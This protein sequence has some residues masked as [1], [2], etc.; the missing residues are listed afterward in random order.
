MEF[1]EREIQKLDL[2]VLLEDF[3]REARRLLLVGLA[4]VVLCGALM[5][6]RTKL[7]YHPQYQ[8]SASFT[9]KVADPL[10][11]SISAY[12]TKTAEQMAKTFPYILTNGL[13]QDRIREELGI[14]YMPSVSVSVM[15]NSSVI[16]LSVRDG[17]PNRA[18]DV[19]NAVITHY[20]ENAEFV[21]GAT[22]LALLDES[23]VPTAP[24]NPLNLKDAVIK[25]AV[26]GL[27]IWFVI[28]LV[29]AM[30]KTTIHNEDMLRRLLSFDCFAHVPT[31]KV[32]GQDSCPL[33]HK[34][35]R[36]PEFSEAIRTLRMRVER[37]MEAEKKKVLLVSSAIP[38]EGKTTVAIN[39]AISAARRGRRVLII[40][41]DLRNPSV[42]KG[43]KV[44]TDRSL[45]DFL[46]GKATV[47]DLICPTETENLFIIPG[48]SGG[49]GV[50]NQM[51]RIRGTSMIQAARNLFDLVILD[52]P[53]CSMLADAGE[54][55]ELADVGLLV[56]RQDYASRD[57]ILDGVQRL[58]EA[59]LPMI[60]WVFNYTERSLSSGEGYGYGYGG[61]YGYEKKRGNW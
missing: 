60:G 36:K 58:G 15:P 33:L 57:Q 54:I 9:V 12:N 19:L 47:R 46:G 51:N 40:D 45:V 29:M 38:G 39:L 34:G 35:R 18:Y 26:L 50:A 56:V 24:V 61:N 59:D 31:V 11:S 2:L 37:V 32:P 41:C 1:D 14:P 21:V 8:A 3:L 22:V 16:T 55:A 27:G 53:P 28:V 52:T 5:A 25:G 4:L 23:G 10:Y 7:G 17:D 30:S 42:A 43:L 44:K 6:L 13:L 48:G 20:P 49:P